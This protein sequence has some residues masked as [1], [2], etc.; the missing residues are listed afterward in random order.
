MGVRVSLAPHLLRLMNPKDRVC[1]GV[2]AIGTEPEEQGKFARWLKEQ[3]TAGRLEYNWDATHK[4]R[5]G[6]PGWPDFTVAL[7]GGKTLLI[8]FKVNIDLSPPQAAT[9]KNLLRL[10]HRAEVC[11]SAAEAIG[12]VERQIAGESPLH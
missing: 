11:H 10:G 8:E 7:H 5:T 1:Y 6:K 9:L 2:E 4:K 12:F 3:W